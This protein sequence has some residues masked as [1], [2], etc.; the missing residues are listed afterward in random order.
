MR[1]RPFGSSGQAVSAVGLCV[2]EDAA[3]AHGVDLVFAALEA[4]VNV[5]QVASGDETAIAVMHDAL[6]Q[7]E[8][9]LLFVMLRAGVQRDGRGGEVRDFSP[10]AL[11]TAL[12]ATGS[13]LRLGP[14]DLI[15]LDD[16]GTEELSPR[17]LEALRAERDAGLV[18][19]VGVAG[20]GEPM[21]AYISS[22]SFDVLATPY[23]LLSGW[24]ERNR[25]KAAGEQNMPVLGY[26]F[27]PPELDWRE[28]QAAALSAKKADG[29]G[30]LGLF[31][32]AAPAPAA[33]L[34][35]T[36][37]AFLDHIKGWTAQEICLAFALTEP[38][39]CSTLISP[40]SLEEV[41]SL[42]AVP[43]RD[44]PTYIAAQIE[45][46]RFTAQPKAG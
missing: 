40:R 17:A 28:R 42:T 16:P 6:S 13:A 32:R 19:T 23:H 10:A 15:L 31:K 45:M 21:D 43:D 14:F 33:A 8:R 27:M 39:L 4:G 18:R 22:R 24:K 41:E 34:A 35:S 7:V 3:G 36:P 46:A 38:G 30:A 26:R 2:T 44:M 20:D 29:G 5:F 11:V 25:L 37:Y 1:Y 12:R 9:R